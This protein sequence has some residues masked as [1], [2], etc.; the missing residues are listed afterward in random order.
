MLAIAL[1]HGFSFSVALVSQIDL[2]GGVH[3]LFS[4]G[5]VANGKQQN[6]QC[7]I[8]GDID[9]S[10]QHVLTLMFCIHAHTQVCNVWVDLFCMYVSIAQTKDFL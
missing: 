2:D 10:H 3:P 6:N 7:E 5:L 1:L 9:L 8:H 4:V